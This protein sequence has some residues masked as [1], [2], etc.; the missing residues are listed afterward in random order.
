MTR[1]DGQAEYAFFM[2]HGDVDVPSSSDMAMRERCRV[3]GNKAAGT[4]RAFTEATRAGDFGGGAGVEVQS[5]QFHVQFNTTR[6][7]RKRVA[8]ST[9]FKAFDRQAFTTYVHRYGLYD[10]DGARV[11]RMS[12][13][14]VDT[15][16]GKHGW[17]GF[18]GMWFPPDVN[19]VNG[20][21]LV[22]RS[23]EP[24]QEPQTYTAIVVPGRLEKHT[25]RAITLRD[26]IDEDFQTFDHVARVELL[27]KWT[28][29]DF[30]KTAHRQGS[31]W[32]PI[33]PPVSIVSS[34]TAG[35]FVHL[36]AQHR[37]GIEFQW[38]SGA[39]SNTTE[40]KTRV[41][42]VITASSPELA[43]GDLAVLG[44]VRRLKAAISQPEA[45]Y[46]SSQSPHFLDAINVMDVKNYVFDK[47]TLLL[48]LDNVTVGLAPGVTVTQGP[49]LNGFECGPMVTSALNSLNEL[50]QQNTTFVWM[51]GPNQ[52][53]Q[54]RT[55]RDANNAVVN[56]D[57]PLSFEYT[58]VETG[59]PFDGRRFMLSWDGNHMGGIPYVESAN[60]R[61]YPQF[62][63]AT[64]TTLTADGATYRLK[65]LQGEQVMNQISDVNGV[66]AANGFD[67]T[68]NLLVPPAPS[69]VDPAI[70]ARPVLNDVAPRFVGGVAQ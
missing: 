6:L 65:Q 11:N 14:P 43:G 5:E 41:T 39:L 20:Q 25:K 30:V 45:N 1:N 60:H 17:V 28:G 18:H 59:S 9:D 12:G 48:E 54:L 26:I 63:L 37:G 70:G 62:N 50:Q 8:N 24:G 49:G 40:A 46:A 64:G 55:V 66:I 36:F 29:S 44:Y 19:V 21:A 7:V 31:N 34:Y 56:F 13:F 42:D 22:R 2:S 15:A 32:N 33:D 23:F 27:V 3:V 68:T 10:V 58:H 52:W 67:L 61:F 35:Q 47:A 38:P 69:Y 4:G 53:N 57:P 51:T 16:D